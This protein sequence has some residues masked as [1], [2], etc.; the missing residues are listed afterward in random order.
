MGLDG[1]IVSRNL[2]KKA[3][4]WILGTE[5]YEGDIEYLEF[6]HD[7]KKLLGSGRYSNVILIDSMSGASNTIFS[8][9]KDLL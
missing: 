9:E 1:R 4:N 2:A 6:S 7:S 8:Q 5:D 3:P